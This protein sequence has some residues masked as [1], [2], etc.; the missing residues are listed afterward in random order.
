MSDQTSDTTD[1]IIAEAAEPSMEDILAS[2][3]KIISEDDSSDNKHMDAAVLDL[4][5]PTIEA[6]DSVLDDILDLDNTAS[7]DSVL[8]LSSNDTLE[9]T[10][11]LVIP[12]VDDFNPV[13]S[14]VN[15][16]QQK[17]TDRDVANFSEDSQ[18]ALD[19]IDLVLSSENIIDT[20][21]N[22]RDETDIVELTSGLLE[23]VEADNEPLLKNASVQG[24]ATAIDDDMDLI[25]EIQDL[26]IEDTEDEVLDADDDNLSI[27]SD[28]S[29]LD[30]VKSLMADLTDSSF[31]DDDDG[32]AE[33]DI[34]DTSL[35]VEDIQDR[36]IDTQTAKTASQDEALL[37]EQDDI[38]ND[39]LD[40][41]LE[42][43]EEQNLSES[44][45]ELTVDEVAEAEI[46][47]DNLLLQ[48]AKAA[49][50]EA[51]IDSN[52]VA[53]LTEPEMAETEAL[54]EV[55]DLIMDEHNDEAEVESDMVASLDILVED[56]DE[57]EQINELIEPEENPEMAKTAR[58]DTILDEVTETAAAGAFASLNQVVEEKAI[59][60]ESGPRVGELVQDA[61]RPMLKEWLD[62]N[63]KGIVE[64]AVAKEVKRISSG[65]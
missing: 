7:N 46:A 44:D 34:I 65:K 21:D 58:N 55:L 28:E 61:L 29:D 32:D 39:I 63:L 51:D 50:A 57:T 33:E 42:S 3:R 26:I 18:S 1:G 8:E 48:I 30:L 62:E 40:M 16:L 31:L 37:A 56:S 27:S 25:S 11:D 47:E 4:E 6:K 12:E 22:H 54:D 13:S 15:D 36:K 2:I 35:A 41:A 64:R 59:Y 24:T 38:L 5:S 45:L 53:E 19:D 23:T 9:L 52:S 17:L 14:V 10:D 60:T 20:L 49:E 43:Q